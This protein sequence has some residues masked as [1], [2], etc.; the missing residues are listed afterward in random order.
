MSRADAQRAQLHAR[1]LEL[2][3][4]QPITAQI[5]PGKGAALD[6]LAEAV[7]ELVLQH[8]QD[9][10]GFCDYEWHING[11]DFVGGFERN[12]E[13]DI[14]K[15]CRKTRA[16]HILHPLLLCPDEVDRVLQLDKDQGRA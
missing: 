7:L 5:S 15:V 14:C 12:D 2:L 4:R 9:A 13:P 16:E 11:A 3:G 10:G 6:A 1:V 8:I